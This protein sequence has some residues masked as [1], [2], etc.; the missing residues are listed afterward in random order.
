MMIATATRPMEVTDDFIRLSTW[1]LLWS[2]GP[3]AL[4][5]SLE[6]YLI[7]RVIAGSIG[8]GLGSQQTLTR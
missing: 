6:V 1:P 5:I 3:L 2:M 8:D 4:A 7:G